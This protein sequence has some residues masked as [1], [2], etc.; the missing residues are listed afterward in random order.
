MISA[1]RKEKAERKMPLNATIRNLTIYAS[2][3]EEV[4]ILDQ[5]K[6]DIEGTCKTERIDIR[7]EEGEGKEVPEYP[8]VRF[9]VDR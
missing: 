6:E 2:T 8:N 1:V 4:N 7:L 5:S 9:A 3:K